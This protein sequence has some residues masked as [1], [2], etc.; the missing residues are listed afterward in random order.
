MRIIKF[1]KSI[2]AA[3]VDSS[4]ELSERVFISLTLI[5]EIVVFFALIGDIILRENTNSTNVMMEQWTTSK[6]K[7]PFWLKSKHFPILAH[8][9]IAP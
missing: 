3:A 9:F 7:S 5:S 2:S 4:R 6:I 1:F 8:Y